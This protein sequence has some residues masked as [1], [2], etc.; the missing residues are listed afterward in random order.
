[1]VIREYSV[2]VIGEVERRV[3]VTGTS[4]AEAEANAFAEWSRVTGGHVGTAEVVVGVDGVS[5]IKEVA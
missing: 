1:M 3:T 5:K 4:L 2:L